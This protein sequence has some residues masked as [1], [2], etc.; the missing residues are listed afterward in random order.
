M[1]GKVVSNKMEKCITV[2]VERKLRHPKYGKL[3]KKTKK[4]KARCK[5]S[6]IFVEGQSVE[7]NYA[8][9][10]AKTVSWMVVE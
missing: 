5:N 7:I 1:I 10:L 6:K 3:F 2:L 8:G 9:K 4:Y